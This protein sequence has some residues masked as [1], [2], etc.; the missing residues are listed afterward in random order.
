MSNDLLIQFH[1][2]VGLTPEL[3]SVSGSVVACSQTQCLCLQ[4]NSQDTHT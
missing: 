2:L 1:E 4:E 3:V